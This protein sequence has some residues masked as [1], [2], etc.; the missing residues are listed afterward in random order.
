MP[1][2]KI[3]K[4]ELAVDLLAFIV[5]SVA[6]ATGVNV[7]MAPNNIAP[8]G[9][10][11]ISII[12]SHF[13]GLPIGTIIILLN[14]PL[15][16]WGITTIRKQFILKSLVGTVLTS[17][18]IDLLKGFLPEY[19][20]DMLLAS[21]FGGAF[22]GIGLALI[23]MR[24]GSTGGTD[25]A[26]KLVINHKSNLSMGKVMLI[27]DATVVLLSG[28]AFKSIEAALHS[29]IAIYISSMLIDTL[30][31]G[32]ERGKMLLIISS[33]SDDIASAILEHGGRGVTV[34]DAKGAYTGHEKKV[35]L[36]AVRNTESSALKK[37]ILGIDP[38]AFVVLCE[39]GQV[40]GEGFDL[41]PFEKDFY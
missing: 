12:I 30:L 32:L 5:G 16:I 20:T 3:N 17:V 19:K 24:G 33:K 29:T 38:E 26:G 37:L 10:T 9:A 4:K 2:S 13:S 41:S 23:I 39:T 35:L 21:I 18:A 22:I 8:G 6:F 28:L 1:L 25:L 7:F 31:Y 14:I 11:G 36:T 40:I 27:I 34:L 15:F